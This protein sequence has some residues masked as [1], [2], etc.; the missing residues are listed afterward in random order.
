MSNSGKSPVDPVRDAEWG[1]YRVK[2]HYGTVLAA[3]F[4]RA[5]SL[6]GLTFFKTNYYRISTYTRHI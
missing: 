4:N 6:T 2:A 5:K 3:N 1:S